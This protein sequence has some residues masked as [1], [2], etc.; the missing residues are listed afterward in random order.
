MLIPISHY[1]SLSISIETVCIKSINMIYTLFSRCLWILK[2]SCE[3]TSRHQGSLVSNRKL[4]V[5]LLV[6][7]RANHRTT[8]VVIFG[9]CKWHVALWLEHSRVSVHLHLWLIELLRLRLCGRMWF[10][11]MESQQSQQEGIPVGCIPSA[12][13]ATTRCQ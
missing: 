9:I 12:L 8:V 11:S 10:F 13:V 2:T 1:I 6:R 4:P 5:Y 3:T 7:H